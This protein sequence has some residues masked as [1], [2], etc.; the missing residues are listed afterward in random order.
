[1]PIVGNQD[2]NEVPQNHLGVK[3]TEDGLTVVDSNGVSKIALTVDAILS[4][5]NL[6][7]SQLEDGKIYLII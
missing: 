5:D 2:G 1:M 6:D 3:A 4:K 7:V